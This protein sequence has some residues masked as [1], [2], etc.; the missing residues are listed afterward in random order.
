[1]TT[2]AAPT[3]HFHIGAIHPVPS[4]E[5]TAAIVAALEMMW[6]RPVAAATTR[7]NVAWRFSGRWWAAPLAVS[8]A[9]P[10]R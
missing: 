5:E 1:M 6:P 3:P 4:V 2:G 9:R 8:R 10:Q 7:A